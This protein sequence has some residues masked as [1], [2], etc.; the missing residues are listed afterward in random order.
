M[1]RH[2]QEARASQGVLDY[3]KDYVGGQELRGALYADA[4]CLRETRVVMG[5]GEIG[6]CDRRGREQEAA[7]V[8]LGG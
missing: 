8:H 5:R 7:A 6:I 1:Q 3:L 2:L 4:S